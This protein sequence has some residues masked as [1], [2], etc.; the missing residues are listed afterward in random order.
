MV[1]SKTR[2]FENPIGIYHA[3][4]KCPNQSRLSLPNYQNVKI[5]YTYELGEGEKLD[6][7]RRDMLTQIDKDFQTV[8]ARDERVAK[9]NREEFDLNRRL[10]VITRLK[11]DPNLVDPDDDLP[12]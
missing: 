10:E 12:F 6:E 9:Y 8:V 7:V 5:G 2:K 1:V 11:E 4:N 3:C